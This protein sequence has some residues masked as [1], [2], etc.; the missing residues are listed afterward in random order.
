MNFTAG[1]E[2]EANYADRSREIRRAAAVAIQELSALRSAG[3]LTQ[4]ALATEVARIAQE[5]L[6]P[7]GCD[8][9]VQRMGDGIT[10]FLIKVQNTG[11]K[12]DLIRS[13]FHRDHG[14]IP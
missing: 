6:H 3:P 4:E 11:R 2:F 13:F 8:L 14:S 12:Y 1:S 7:H 5:T 9:I 10:R